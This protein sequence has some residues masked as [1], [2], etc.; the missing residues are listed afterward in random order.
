MKLKGKRLLSWLMTVVMVLS[1][2]PTTALAAEVGETE[3][4]KTEIPPE[5]VANAVWVL[6]E[7]T[8]LAPNPKTDCEKIEHSHDDSC[9][10]KNCDH[11]DATLNGHFQSCYGGEWVVCKHEEGDDTAHT[12]AFTVDSSI[13]D[14]Y[15]EINSELWSAIKA[16]CGIT[17]SRSW[18]SSYTSLK[19]HT[20]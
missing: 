10:T 19:K 3:T 15:D 12:G 4:T 13:K 5:N 20:V 1:M 8:I 17:A 6:N 9:Y 7:S 14:T 16:Y 18:C 2:L 11:A